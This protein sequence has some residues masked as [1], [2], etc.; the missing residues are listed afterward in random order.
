MSRFFVGQTKLVIILDLESDITDADE[1][2]IKYISPQGKKGSWPAVV[3]N[4]TTGVIGY[5][6][7]SAS[8]LFEAGDWTIWAFIT[9]VLGK[10]IASEPVTLKINEEG[11]K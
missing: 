1:V 8:D 5:E 9:D 11:K 7:Q 6:V 4:P 10:T 2:L 3:V